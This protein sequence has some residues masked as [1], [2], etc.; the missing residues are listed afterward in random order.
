M[1]DE[2]KT[3]ENCGEEVDEYYRIYSPESPVFNMILCQD[4]Y[5]TYNDDEEEDQKGG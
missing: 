4:C 5:D 2:P 1:M 3:C